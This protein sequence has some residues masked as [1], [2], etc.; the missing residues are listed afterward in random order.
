MPDNSAS[1]PLRQSEC[2]GLHVRVRARGEVGADEEHICLRVAVPK[3]DA[4]ARGKQRGVGGGR[5][6]GPRAVGR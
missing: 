1:K 6:A 2:V 5:W 3:I 4:L